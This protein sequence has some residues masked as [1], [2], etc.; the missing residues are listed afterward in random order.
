[1]TATG[2]TLADLVLRWPEIGVVGSLAI[3]LG[4][5]VVVFAYTT[6]LRAQ[7]HAPQA[8]FGLLTLRLMAGAC[9]AL[10]L[11]HPACIQ[12][13]AT[14]EKPHLAVVLDDSIS[15][16]TPSPDSSGDHESTRYTRATT[17]LR[18]K[19]SPHLAETHQ[20]AVFDVQA[21]ALE[22]DA[23]PAAPTAERS[24]LSDTLTRIQRTFTGRALAGIVMLSDGAE[25]TDQ[26]DANRLDD[27]RVPVHAIE[28]VD[29]AARATG[30]PDLAIEA[31]SASQ[32]TIVGNTVRA[33]VDLTATGDVGDAGVPLTILTGDRTVAS[34]TVRW[35]PGA[36]TARA[37]LEFVPRRPGQY[38]YTVELGGLPD[39]V[40][41]A[42]NRDVFP[43][44]VRARAL[45]VFYLDGVL[46]WEGKFVRQALN[47]DPD[48]NVVST[49]RTVPPG[50][51]RGSQGIITAH[52]LADVDV[53]ILGD[54]EAD[55]FST[56][57]LDAL[58][59]WVTDGG[60][61][62]VVTGGYR[63]FGPA[64]FGR[65]PLRHI[66]PVEF[67]ADP[68][69]QIERPFSL[70]LTEA[71]RQHS[72]FSLTR[73]RVRDAAFY[74]ALPPLDGCS[75]IA[76]VKPGAQVLA[77]NPTVTG[78]D[79]S[80]GYPVMV[81][82]RVGAGQ[83]L[84]FSVDTTWRWRT[85]VGGFTGEAAFYTTFWGQ[86]VRALVG[87]DE[88]TTNPLLVSTDATRYKPGQTI[89]LAIQMA[90]GADEPVEERGTASEVPPMSAGVY[91]LSAR[92]FTES[93]RHL[94]IPLTD[95]G[96]GRQRGSLSARAAG[97]LDISVIAEPP[98]VAED[99][100][101]TGD[102][103]TR[104]ITVF[105]DHADPERRNPR[106]DPQWLA[107]VAQLTGGHVVTP[108][109][110]DAWITGLPA[111]RVAV[112]QTATTGWRGDHLLGGLCLLLLCTEWV[113]RR[114]SQLV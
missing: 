16:S 80:Q 2:N 49:V 3:A 21:R 40:D 24:P 67:S 65:S 85:I 34:T 90:T 107:R 103:Y 77:I 36:V 30:P 59:S 14:F 23:L 69:P 19:L 72:I 101:Q 43:L 100:L 82:Q 53:V 5:A 78:P 81:T 46:R 110:L 10:A 9:A 73:D 76:A 108:D 75:R 97:R 60:G 39:E 109:Q 111:E 1:M 96:N 26:P 37:E 89:E 66:L 44:T 84:V 22:P 8:R 20:V 45:T 92:A 52:Q 18:E 70:K 86:L 51:D 47:A 35:R 68:N 64:G 4:F 83:T 12:E 13:T 58:T 71:G 28:L 87:G 106:P 42:N 15:M 88:D 29:P 91:N 94:K 102:V 105:V 17:I 62:L 11:A 6:G 56:D 25:I 38:S 54:I 74:H 7:Q 113:L 99:A 50:T 41:L 61:A 31:I 98:A 93:G 57:E 55:F 32:R 33:T 63:S 27:L 104:T 114:W 79:G 112:V 95:L 48:L